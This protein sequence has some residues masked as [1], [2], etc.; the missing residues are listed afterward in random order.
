MVLNWIATH[1][2][3]I[4]AVVSV[5]SALVFNATEMRQ[6][7]KARQVETLSKLTDRHLEIW[8][9]FHSQPDLMRILA[10]DVDVEDDTLSR[11]EIHFVSFLLL[12]LNVSYWA[13]RRGIFRQHDNIKAEIRSFLALPIPRAAWRILRDSHDREFVSFI[14][15]ALRQNK[16]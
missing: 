14:E 13:A 7:T 3:G 2:E 15:D 10:T 11:K 6:S 1:W 9:Y 4:V 12:N 5:T 8:T 16:F